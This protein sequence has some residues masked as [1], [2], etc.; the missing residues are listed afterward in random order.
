[1][2]AHGT[3]LADFPGRSALTAA[4]AALL[5]AP[6]ALGTLSPHTLASAVP[7]FPSLELLPTFASEIL[8]H[9]KPIELSQQKESK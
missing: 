5:T 8:H 9:C 3:D 4:S 2:E 7:P 6:P 1:M